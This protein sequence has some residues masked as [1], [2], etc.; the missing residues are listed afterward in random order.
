ME[1]LK[2]LEM[3]VAKPVQ[4]A[5]Q[6]TFLDAIQKAKT[7]AGSPNLTVQTPR[8]IDPKVDKIFTSDVS[9]ACSH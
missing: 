9:V 7:S 5:K 6:V 4:Q 1:A 3:L 2:R 8:V